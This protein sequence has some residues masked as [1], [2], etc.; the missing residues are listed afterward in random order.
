MSFKEKNFTYGSTEKHFKYGLREAA[1]KG[2]VKVGDWVKVPNS[3]N[4]WD[5]GDSFCK[6]KY[7]SKIRYNIINS[8]D[9]DTFCTC[10][11]LNE[12]FI[13]RVDD[14]EEDQTKEESSPYC[15]C[16]KCPNCGKIIEK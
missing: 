6:I 4:C 12:P 14:G 16:E 8:N 3:T 7:I 15:T 11:D 9:D 2:E 1:T 5:N 13:L 10:N